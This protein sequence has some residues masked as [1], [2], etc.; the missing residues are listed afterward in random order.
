MKNLKEAFGLKLK[1]IRKSRKLTQETLAEKIDLSPRQ[2]IRI[3]NGENFPSAE[4]I[5]KISIALQVG[6]DYLFNFNWNDDLMYFKKGIY[7]KPLLKLIKKDNK[8][9]VKKNSNDLKISLSEHLNEDLYEAELFK[10]SKKLK[11]PV[12]VEFFED[13]RRT[14]IKVFYP[15]Q[16][17]EEILSENEIKKI[18]LYNII[19]Q[20]IEE[21]STDYDKLK[22]INMALDSL[23]NKKILKDFILFLKGMNLIN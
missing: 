10:L 16:K 13:K 4:T 15:G 22:Y 11:K 7:N 23:K 1:E 18:E 17:I 19:T 3:E 12:M 9:M 20:K 6:L 21:I 14:G 8:F 2:L 5:G